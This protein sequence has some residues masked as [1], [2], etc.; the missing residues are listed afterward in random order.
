MRLV[1]PSADLAIALAIASAN[2]ELSLPHTFAAFG[3]ISLAGEVRPV[4]SAA[5][6]VTEAK[7]LGF[8][9]ILGP[10]ETQ[11]RRAFRTAFD[12]QPAKGS[13]VSPSHP[14]TGSFPVQKAPA[15]KSPLRL[16]D[17]GTA[18]D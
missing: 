16:V 8:T 3:E 2:S 17:P 5:L 13:R 7:R 1:D 6:R 14:S 18:R 12:K 10:E 15:S 11:I 4:A 9:D